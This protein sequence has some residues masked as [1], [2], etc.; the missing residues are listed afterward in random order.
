MSHQSAEPIRVLI[1]DDE[2]AVRTSYEDILA[3]FS[4]KASD[5][6]TDMRS[7]LFGGASPPVMDQDSFELNFCLVPKR[8]CAAPKRRCATVVPLQ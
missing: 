7:R 3:S 6:L 1:A 2:P 4:P 5:A 8:P